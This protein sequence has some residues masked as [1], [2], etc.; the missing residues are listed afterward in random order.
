MKIAIILLLFLEIV[1]GA[2][3]K[4]SWTVNLFTVDSMKKV[5]FYIKKYVKKPSANIYIF[6]E[7]NKYRVTYG[8]F[9]NYLKGRALLTKESS[10][11]G[12]FHPYVLRHKYNLRNPKAVPTLIKIIEF[13]KKRMVRKNVSQKKKDHTKKILKKRIE[14]KKN[15]D[16]YRF[17]ISLAYAKS[18]LDGDIKLLSTDTSVDFKNDLGLDETNTQV[19]PEFFVQKGANTV[20][21][22]YFQSDSSSKQVLKKD[23]TLENTLISKGSNVQ[24][25]VDLEYLKLMYKR[26][27]MSYNIGLNYY[28]IENKIDIVP[29]TNPIIHLNGSFGIFSVSIDKEYLFDDKSLFWNINKG[30]T[31]DVDY[32]NYTIGANYYFN[33]SYMLSTA[34]DVESL[35]IDSDSYNSNIQLNK[36]YFQ[37]TRKF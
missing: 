20:G 17:S 11:I 36:L 14:H 22:K 9:P 7:K 15:S 34:Y 25:K 33:N 23:V 4:T 21:L 19:I 30:I 5:N 32:L 24:S 3:N 8:V 10:S 12:V 29:D 31:G 2:T 16:D 1:V 18:A 37:I 6:K 26:E 13:G 27:F 35:E 28:K